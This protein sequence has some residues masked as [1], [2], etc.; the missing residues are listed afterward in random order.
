MRPTGLILLPVG[1]VLKGSNYNF[2]LKILYTIINVTP[3]KT[4]ITTIIILTK[5]NIKS[6][7]I[8]AMQKSTINVKHKY[9]NDLTV[10]LVFINNVPL[11]SYY[12]KI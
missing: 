5:G 4:S 9:R 1:R 7:D 10:S 12:H 2:S 6:I 8:I 3:P 11:H